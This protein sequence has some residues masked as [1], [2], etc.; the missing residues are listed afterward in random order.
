[1]RLS[2]L[3][4]ISTIVSLWLAFATL[5]SAQQMQLN[6]YSD[7]YCSN[8]GGSLQ[9]YWAESMTVTGSACYNYNYGSSMLIANCYNSDWCY[10]ELY[11]S[12][13]CSG[14]YASIQYS[15]YD[16]NTQWEFNCLF[17]AQDIHSLRCFNYVK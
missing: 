8:Y 13:G 14:D 6:Y 12:S 1:M 3:S 9:Y 16:R 10:C 11:Y 4:P 7:H 5:C 15:G 2:T 17:N